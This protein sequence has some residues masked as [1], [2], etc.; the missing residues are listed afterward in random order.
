MSTVIYLTEIAAN[1]GV[2]RPHSNLKWFESWILIWKHTEKTWLDA[3]A[4]TGRNGLLVWLEPSVA[5]SLLEDMMKDRIVCVVVHRWIH[6]VPPLGWCAGRANDELGKGGD[7][8]KGKDGDLIAFHY[9][10]AFKI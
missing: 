9:K 3:D 7:L 1:L 6:L 5:L 8:E 10:G 4:N 2:E